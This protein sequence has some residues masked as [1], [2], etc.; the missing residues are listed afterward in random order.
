MSKIKQAH[1]LKNKDSMSFDI[2][3]ITSFSWVNDYFSCFID[4]I[5]EKTVSLQNHERK[6]TENQDARGN[7][8]GPAG[9]P[10]DHPVSGVGISRQ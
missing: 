2:R 4:G 8:G 7:L 1:E 5:S 10:G 6:E 3:P 9:V